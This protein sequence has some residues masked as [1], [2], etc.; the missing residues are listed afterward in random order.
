M[1]DGWQGNPHPRVKEDVGSEKLWRLQQGL[2]TLNG[3]GRHS[4]EGVEHKS[5]YD[6]AYILAGSLL[7]NATSFA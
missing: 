1:E 7:I 4:L 3:R 6:L 2:W 5:G